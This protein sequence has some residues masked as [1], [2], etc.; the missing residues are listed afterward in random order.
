MMGNILKAFQLAVIEK[1]ITKK[2]LLK[3]LQEVADW[4]G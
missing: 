2:V 4:K 1:K 3:I